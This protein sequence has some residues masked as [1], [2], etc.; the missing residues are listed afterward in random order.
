MNFI[1]KKKKKSR[2]SNATSACVLTIL[3]VNMVFPICRGLLWE[4][5]GKG[6][7]NAG[8]CFFF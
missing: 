2:R 5:G 4:K 7:K 8:F 1:K 3:D 6:K